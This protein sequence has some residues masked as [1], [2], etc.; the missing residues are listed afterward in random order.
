MK[1]LLKCRSWNYSAG[2]GN[3]DGEDGACSFLKSAAART[4]RKL[5]SA[6]SSSSCESS[7]VNQSK[8]GICWRK[9][10]RKVPAKSRSRQDSSLPWGQEVSW[11]DIFII[12]GTWQRTGWHRS[13]PHRERFFQVGESR[14]VSLGSERPGGNFRSESDLSSTFFSHWVTGSCSHLVIWSIVGQWHLETWWF[15]FHPGHIPRTWTLDKD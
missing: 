8:Q 9:S 14:Q 1:P 12:C 13:R 4:L 10:L 11:L 7:N 15:P 5:I 3:L 2:V 6:Q